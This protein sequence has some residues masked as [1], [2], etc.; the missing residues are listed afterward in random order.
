MQLISKKG[1][2]WKF[3]QMEGRSSAENISPDVRSAA[4]CTVSKIYM[5]YT[6][7]VSVPK[8]Y[9]DFGYAKHNN[10]ILKG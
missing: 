8:S 3:F 10:I 7:A 5:V 2:L 4:T 1:I 6:S 9:Q